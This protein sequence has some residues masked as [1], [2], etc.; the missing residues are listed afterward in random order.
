MSPQCTLF[1]FTHITSIRYSFAFLWN[2]SP[3]FMYFTG[4]TFTHTHTHTH[5]ASHSQGTGKYSISLDVKVVCPEALYSLHTQVAP[6][7]PL[8]PS[9]P[10]FKK[11]TFSNFNNCY[12]Y[13]KP[14]LLGFPK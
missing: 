2:Y 1:K 6:S 4:S 9:P 14:N 7:P 13:S 10:A 11:F 3:C 8:I 12:Y 5:T